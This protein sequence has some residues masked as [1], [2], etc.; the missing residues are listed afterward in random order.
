MSL[1]TTGSQSEKVGKLMS[2]GHTALM[3]HH[4]L[5]IAQQASTRNMQTVPQGKALPVC[6]CAADDTVAG[7][8]QGDIMDPLMESF[9][10]NLKHFSS[11]FLVLFF[12]QRTGAYDGYRGVSPRTNLTVRSTVMSTHHCSTVRS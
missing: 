11:C 3:Q 5:N 7:T 4:A 8:Q 6:L 12:L 9:K 10:C 2:E 1:V